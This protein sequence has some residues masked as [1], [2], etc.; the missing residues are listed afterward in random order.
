MKAVVDTRFLI[1]SLTA[2]DRQ[3]QN[4]T[5][6]T[7]QALQ[8]TENMGIVP[9]IVIH[10]FYR[11]LLKNLGKDVA[12]LH[13][14]SVLRL[15]FEV[16]VLDIPIAVEAAKLRCKYAELPTAD[17]VIAATAVVCGC[18]CVLTDDKHFKQIREIKTRWI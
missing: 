12:E 3:F 4:W 16:A 10:E 1:D 11:F 5:R 2:E 7:L 8:K 18:D 6:A 14:S 13:V 15:D 9:T 17:A